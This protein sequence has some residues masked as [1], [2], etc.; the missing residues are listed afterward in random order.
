MKKN[1]ILL[2]LL[3]LFIIG[4][5]Y[6]SF[7]EDFIELDSSLYNWFIIPAIPI[8]IYYA[9]SLTSAHPKNINGKIAIGRIIIT[10]LVTM[11]V[12]TAIQGYLVLYNC[13]IGKQTEIDVKGKVTE[14]NFP[15]PK[16]LNKYTIRVSLTGKWEDITV[17]V[18]SKD[19]HIG[20]LFEKKMTQGSLG[21]LYASE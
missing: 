3:I 10:V 15:S 1:I 8:G 9:F 21:I 11:F 20:Q 4:G 19:Y 2:L 6:G 14:V 16:M 17:V 13:A 12:F 7:S 18:P 5:T